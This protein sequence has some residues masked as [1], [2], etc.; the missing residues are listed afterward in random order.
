MIHEILVAVDFSDLAAAV[1]E[2]AAMLAFQFKS[3][4]HIIHIETPVPAFVGNEIGPQLPSAEQSIEEIKQQQTDLEAMALHLRQKEI[5]SDWELLQ[6]PVVD[7]IVDKA[8]QIH[9]DL[10]IVGAHNHGFLYRAFIG[11]V[12]TGVLKNAPCPVLI[13]PEK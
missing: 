2:H 12:S 13:I 9:A 10:L 11:S 3:H 1:I 5:E 7:T 6:G 4:V 8:K